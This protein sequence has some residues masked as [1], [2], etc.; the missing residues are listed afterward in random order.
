MSINSL[1]C[2]GLNHALTSHKIN[3]FD[4]ELA[5][6]L[7]TYMLLFLLFLVCFSLVINFLSNHFIMQ[8]M[9][10]DRWNKFELV[11]LSI[12]TLLYYEIPRLYQ[13]DFIML[14]IISW[15]KKCQLTDETSLNLF[16]CQNKTENEFQS[17]TA[18]QGKQSFFFSNV[19]I[20][21]Y[22]VFW[23]NLTQFCYFNKCF[24]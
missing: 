5:P 22:R 15:C 17:M 16:F 14:L 6:V 23:S 2:N 18:S 7:G 19:I 12:D 4:R 21:F 9:S 13:S 24:L 10:N 1:Q 20:A 8:Q 11:V 3:I